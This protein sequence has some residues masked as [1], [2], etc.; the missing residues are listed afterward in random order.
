MPEYATTIQPYIEEVAAEIMKEAE[1]GDWKF[2]NR[3]FLGPC[4]GDIGIITQ[5]VLSLPSLA[6][7]LESRLKELL[8]LQMVDGNWPATGNTVDKDSSLVQFCHGATGFVISLKALRPFYPDLEARIDDAISKGQEIIWERGLL[9][10]EPSL[11]HGILG[12]GL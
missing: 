5:L 3:R 4:H 10:K 12:N 2:A 1:R 6:Q 11:C 7:T 9:R 8:D